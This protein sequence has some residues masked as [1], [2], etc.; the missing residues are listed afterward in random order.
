MGVAAVDVPPR[1]K[2]PS[3]NAFWEKPAGR[4]TGMCAAFPRGRMPRGK[5]RVPKGVRAREGSRNSG[6]CFFGYFLVTRQ[7]SN[8]PAVR[9]PQVHF[10]HDDRAEAR[11]N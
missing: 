4:R 9:E 3:L 10:I 5:A 2:R 1:M 6:A 8:P 11:T 7:E